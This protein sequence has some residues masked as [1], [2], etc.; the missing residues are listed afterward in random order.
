MTRTI[1]DRWPTALAVV[2]TAGGI[3]AMVL[4]DR[5]V[6]WFGPSV[7][8]MAAIYLLAYAIGRPGS[9]WLAFLVLSVV[10]TVL[11]ILADRGD[12]DPALGM[13]VVLVVLWLAVVA[14]RRYTDRPI[15]TLQTAGAVVF[16]LVTLL[17][18]AVQPRLGIA[19]AGVGFLAH[20]LWDAYHFR[21]NRVVSR[22]WAEFCA[23][24]DIP[25]GVALI[26]VAIL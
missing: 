3:A 26:V 9:A 7:A 19:L 23:V 21:I 11:Q 24:I 12:T 20:G 13:A 10:M 1:T 17:C 18:A 2:A 8:V 15:F 5:E 14:R 25:T 6:D 22:S 16:G 4:A